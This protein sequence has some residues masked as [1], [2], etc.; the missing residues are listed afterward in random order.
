[1]FVREH[2]R[3]AA[4]A[5]HHVVILADDGPDA[6][7]RGLYSTIEEHDGPLQVV[8]FSYR[9]RAARIAYIVAVLELA[10]RLRR[11]GTPVDILHAHV[12]RMGLPAVVA[13][14]LLRRAVVISEHSSEWSER[15]LSSGALRRARIAFRHAALV[16]P[17]SRA[18]QASIEAYGVEGEF[19]V[20]PNAVDT[21]IFYPCER[22]PDA[23]PAR[24]VNVALHEEIKGLDV[25]LQAF[26]LLAESR[27][28]VV[29][30][31]IG[32]G[33]RKGSLER[34]AAELGIADRVRFRGALAPGDVAE[35]LRAADLF[36]LS[37]RSETLGAAVIEALCT[38][39]PVVATAVGGV[40]EVIGEEDGMLVPPG[41][42]DRLATG[43]GAALDDYGRFDRVAIARRARQRFSTQAIGGIWDDIY[44]VL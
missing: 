30:E 27:P 1:V 39:L 2:A 22:I 23:A 31:L 13:G 29:L 14:A 33:P 15:T 7:V 44:R 10:R 38:G 20:V 26:A 43:V 21:E 11:S 6:R 4:S 40:P 19:R 17:V 34:L 24:L 35:A 42:A 5:G 32:D 12:H 25:L 8:R 28:D 16:C 37:S 36:V 9:P 18:L 41:D 3:A